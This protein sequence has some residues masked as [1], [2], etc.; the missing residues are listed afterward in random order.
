MMGR[1]QQLEEENYKLKSLLSRVACDV[2]VENV[3]RIRAEVGDGY[4]YPY[5]VGTV[6]GF[7]SH[8]KGEWEVV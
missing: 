5:I 3:A 2:S 8:H 7:L 4:E 1:I 6:R